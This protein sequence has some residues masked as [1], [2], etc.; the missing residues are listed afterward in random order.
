MNLVLFKSAPQTNT[1][2]KKR[3]ETGRKQSFCCVLGCSEA[4]LNTNTV[5]KSAS[6]LTA[7][8]TTVSKL[9]V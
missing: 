4:K 2:K 1:N 7:N 8:I 6:K 5:N 9:E 3:Q